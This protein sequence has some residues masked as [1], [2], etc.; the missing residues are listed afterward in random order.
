MKSVKNIV[1]ET[2]QKFLSEYYGDAEFS[3][4]DKAFMRRVGRRPDVERRDAPES[5]RVIGKIT[6]DMT[7]KTLEKPVPIHK[8]PKNLKGFESNVRGVLVNNGDFYL[9][10]SSEVV[11]DQM[12][13]IMAREGIIPFQS[14]FYYGER[15]PEEF[16]AV[17]RVDNSNTFVP[18]VVYE[19]IPN[20][21]HEIIDVGNN[22]HIS[23]Y[24][25]PTIL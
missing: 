13:E 11:H 20:Y 6:Q 14:R 7:R 8:N 15:Y 1:K 3:M 12:L 5:E 22:A 4:A 2:I 10:E 16:I 24:F 9:A 23:F 21:Y 17:E 25:E 18:S 19:T